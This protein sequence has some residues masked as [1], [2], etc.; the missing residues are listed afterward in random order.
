MEPSRIEIL[1]KTLEATPDNT[2]ARYAL[3]LE[4]SRSGQGDQA[5]QAREH[6]QYLLEHHPDYAAAYLQAGMYL[7]K[8]G[9]REEALEIF[10]K[11]VEVN[12]RQGNLHAQS[13]IEAALEELTQ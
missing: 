7:T 4:L 5:D 13:E 8:R 12:R 1:R 10:K 11:G 6:F 2:F 9:Q 3:A